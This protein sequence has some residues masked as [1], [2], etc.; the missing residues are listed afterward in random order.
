MSES[1]SDHA[2]SKNTSSK[3]ASSKYVASSK[4]EE[5]YE[6]KDDSIFE[7]KR[8]K[9]DIIGKLGQG[10]FS[11]VYSVCD[12]ET[13]DEY[14]MK[15]VKSG[16]HYTESAE[17]EIIILENIKG[18]PNLVQIHDSFRIPDLNDDT[19]NLYHVCIVMRYHGKSLTNIWKDKSLFLNPKPNHSI[20]LVMTIRIMIQIL[21]GLFNLNAAGIIHTDLKPENIVYTTSTDSDT[22]EINIHITIIDVGNSHFID[23]QYHNSKIQTRQYRS[24]EAIIGI[25]PYNKSVDIWSLACIAFELATGEYLFDPHNAKNKSYDRDDDHLA[26]MNELRRDTGDSSIQIPI[27]VLKTGKY[28]PVIFKRNTANLQKISDFKFWC[29]E[30]ILNDKYHF[31]E[32]ESKLF[33][34]LLLPMLAMNPVD[35]IDAITA[36]KQ[37]Q[38]SL[39]TLLI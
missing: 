20:P 2:T 15:I 28:Y 10:T 30:D 27:D 22:G 35:R 31:D 39:A 32:K 38:D 21:I 7:G 8:G 26:M 33:T 25:I 36:L 19:G 5:Y 16:R 37:W 3:N 6:I 24:P 4:G 9:Y 23:V 1:N 12:I 13:Q 29:L 34:E 14:A 18:L 11:K 17:D